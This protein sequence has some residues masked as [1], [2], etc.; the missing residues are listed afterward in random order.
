MFS[1][2]VTDFVTWMI[3]LWAALHS[4]SRSSPC[5]TVAPQQPLWEGSLGQSPGGCL[6]ESWSHWKSCPLFPSLVLFSKT[7]PTTPFLRAAC[8]APADSASVLL[9]SV[10]PCHAASPRSLCLSTQ[11]LHKSSSRDPQFLLCCSLSSWFRDLSK[12]NMWFPLWLS[13]LFLHV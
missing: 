4:C 1:R 12:K 8:A 11:C 9:L 6:L 7:V 2:N 3:T 13:H 10:S 5:A